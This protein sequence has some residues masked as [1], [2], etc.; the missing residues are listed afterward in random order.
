MCAKPYTANNEQKTKWVKLG[1]CV[2]MP[3]GKMFG[4][5]DAIPSGAWFNGSIQFFEQDQ[6]SN[7]QQQNN[8]GQQQQQ[9]G[10]GAPQQQQM[11]PGYGN[12]QQNNVGNRP[13]NQSN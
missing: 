8:G 2:L 4:D 10:Y 5:L 6:Q 11:T 3:D 12:Q 1:T 7:G 13:Q 9:G